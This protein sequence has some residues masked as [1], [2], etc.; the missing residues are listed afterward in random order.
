MSKPSINGIK[1]SGPLVPMWIRSHCGAAE[2]APLICRMLAQMRVNIAFWACADPQE[3]Q[4]GLCCIDA[5][6]HVRVAAALL[7]HEQLKAAVYFG[8]EV[9][10]LSF[11]PHQARLDALAT[12]LEALTGC[13]VAIHGCASS[14]AAFTMVV[15]YGRLDQAAA[16]LT[17][18]LALPEHPAAFRADFKVVQE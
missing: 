11:Y 14:I 2:I 15:D 6:D 5:E 17:G 10:L 12:A 18:V 8:K 1:L 13:G 7:G 9:G 4:Q 3:G 16:V